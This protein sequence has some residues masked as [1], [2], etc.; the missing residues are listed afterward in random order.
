MKKITLI[1]SLL[2]SQTIYSTTNPLLGIWNKVDGPSSVLRFDYLND[3]T[4]TLL[5]NDSSSLTL[6]YVVNTSVTPYRI[7]WYFGGR[8]VDLGIWSISENTLTV[9]GSGGDTTTYP[10]S[11]TDPSH[12]NRQDVIHVIPAQN[13]LNVPRSTNITITFKERIDTLSLT[14]NSI[15]LWGNQSG[16][17]TCILRYDTTI[18]ELTMD[19]L[20]NFTPGE[21]VTI[22]LTDSIK[23]LTGRYIVKF[24]WS[25]TIATTAITPM[26][27]RQTTTVG[28]GSNPTSIII[29]DF[30]GDG[31]LDLAVLNHG[32]CNVSILLND[33]RGNFAH[34]STIGV[35][36]YP[37][38]IIAG[39]FDCDGDLDLAVGALDLGADLGTV[40]IFFNDG[41]GVFGFG[42]TVSVDRYVNSIVTGDWNEDGMLD[43]AVSNDEP[44]PKTISILLNRGNGFFTL[45]SIIKVGCAPRSIA[46]GDLDM[47]G[48]LDLAVTNFESKSVSILL[49]NGNGVFIQRSI[50]TVGSHPVS[51]VAGDFN[52]DG[53]LDLAVL[54]QDSCNVYILLNDGSG[55]FAQASTIGVGKYPTSIT[56]GDLDGDGDLDLVV[57]NSNYYLTD[58]GTISILLNNGSGNFTQ[59]SAIG[60]GKHPTSITTGDFDGDGDLDL[61]VA[62]F[63]SDNISIMIN[64]FF[65][66]NVQLGKSSVFFGN[67]KVGEFKDSTVVITNIGS[68]TLKISNIISS[69]ST[70]SARPTTRNLPPS[71]SFSDTLRFIPI[72][73]GNTSGMLLIYSNAPSSPDTIR[74]S[75]YGYGTPVL[76]LNASTITFANVKIGQ[77]K[78]TTM[79][80]TNIGYDTLKLSNIMSPSEAFLSRTSVKAIPPSESF[81]DTLFFAPTVAGPA[82]SIVLIFSN[83]ATSPDTI[84]VSGNGV[85]TSI[86][87]FTKIPSVYS[88]NQNYPNPFNPSTLIRY[89]LPSRSTV[90]LKVYNTLGQQVGELVNSIQEAGYHDVTWQANVCS[91][92]YVY[93]IEAFAVDKQET[94]YIETKKLIVIK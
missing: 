1:L 47:N 82:S 60:V 12:Y 81:N 10:P 33:R 16:L 79:T 63:S 3:S 20:V 11:F 86:E 41:N 22:V 23:T 52:G 93:R 19:P 38:A 39:D 74:V 56:T 36:N 71:K 76:R 55:N 61:A 7:R 58:I 18:F 75:G 34:A 65:F 13:A 92:V 31:Y 59:A 77:I 80:I 5:Q 44:L 45:S 67:V 6:C 15:R 85:L 25:F 32:S 30:N 42:S 62:N 89:G 24:L 88:L 57:T 14:N 54:N 29:G 8:T 43:L 83:A 72:V 40:S 4:V 90:K 84:Q 35:G 27:F 50:D 64:A 69:N 68:D 53:Y 26:Y 2:I 87:T 46:V 73:I 78:D 70:F 51:L 9:Q 66:S 91:G 94:Q 28:V 48:T 17:H 49:N 21:V 37:Y